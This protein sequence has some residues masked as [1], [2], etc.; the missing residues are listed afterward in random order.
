MSRLLTKSEAAAYLK[1]KPSQFTNWIKD[2]RISPA[3]PGTHRWDRVALD[4]DIDRL[5]GIKTESAV[6]SE[7]DAWR[8]RK[9]ARRTQRASQDQQNP[10]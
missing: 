1:L 4:R 6:V 7:L 2:G 9:N 10:R 8:Q 3:I 5:S